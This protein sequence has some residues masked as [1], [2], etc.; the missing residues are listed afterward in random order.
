MEQQISWPALWMFE[1]KWECGCGGCWFCLLPHWVAYDR[2]L[3]ADIDPMKSACLTMIGSWVSILRSYSLNIP[4]NIMSVPKA[5][6]PC[7]SFS[8]SYMTNLSSKCCHLQHRL[9]QWTN[10]RDD[11]IA[12]DDGMRTDWLCNYP[13]YIRAFARAAITRYRMLICWEF[14]YDLD[15]HMSY[16]H[17]KAPICNL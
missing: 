6:L 13:V 4:L 8:W 12:Y 16:A 11:D 14:S 1:Y 17:D 2:I 5:I 9:W 15:T 3:I 7:N 10:I